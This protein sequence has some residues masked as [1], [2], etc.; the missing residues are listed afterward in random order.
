MRRILSLSQICQFNTT[1]MGWSNDHL[2]SDSDADNN[3]NNIVAEEVHGDVCVVHNLSLKYFRLKLIEHFTIKF[4][5]KE[6]V[7]SK[8]RRGAE[9]TIGI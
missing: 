3:N 9:P 1:R 5:K 4:K 2:D 7:W 8:K 6:I